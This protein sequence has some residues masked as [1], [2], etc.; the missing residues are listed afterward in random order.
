MLNF[1][2]ITALLN[3][4]L[5]NRQL[6]TFDG[7]PDDEITALKTLKARVVGPHVLALACL[8]GAYTLDIDVCDNQIGSVLLQRQPDGTENPVLYWFRLLNGAEHAY[9]MRYRNCLAVVLAVLL[10]GPYLGNSRC[11]IRTD[12]NAFNWTRNLT[13]LTGKLACW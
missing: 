11:T 10:R 2:R 7:L 6:Q 9:D 3:K 8:E 12:Q 13:D 1:A 4:K 5:R